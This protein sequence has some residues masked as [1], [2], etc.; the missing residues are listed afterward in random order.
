MYVCIYTYIHTYIYIYIYIYIHTYIHAYIHTSFC[1]DRDV[2]CQILALFCP[3]R[4][5]VLFAFVCVCV[6]VRVC[7][8]VCARERERERENT[9]V[10]SKLP[11]AYLHVCR[12]T[13]L[14]C[15]GGFMV[16]RSYAAVRGAAY[17]SG[18]GYTLLLSARYV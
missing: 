7:V 17:F 12:F 15:G 4:A 5:R 6:C 13:V 10:P 2:S 16:S 18:S 8:C 11:C 14:E 3:D 9:P 1:Q